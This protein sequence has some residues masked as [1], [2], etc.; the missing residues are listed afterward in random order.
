MLVREGLG[1]DKARNLVGLLVANIAHELRPQ[2]RA[3]QQ[4]TSVEVDIYDKGDL[5]PRLM[6]APGTPEQVHYAIVD[7]L[8]VLRMF[9]ELVKGEDEQSTVNCAH[10]TLAVAKGMACSL[11]QALEAASRADEPPENLISAVLAASRAEKESA[12]GE[13]L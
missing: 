8:G 9:S 6:I 10:R 13:R 4:T 2:P 12:D 11:E 5:L 3:K 1:A 7:V